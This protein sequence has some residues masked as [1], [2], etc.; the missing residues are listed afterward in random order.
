MSFQSL[1]G[2]KRRVH[3]SR[4]PFSL[5]FSCTAWKRQPTHVRSWPFGARWGSSFGPTVNQ[6]LKA[7]DPLY[8]QRSRLPVTVGSLP[9]KWELKKTQTFRR[10][11]EAA[12]LHKLNESKVVQEGGGW[13]GMCEWKRK[14]LLFPQLCP[15]RW[16]HPLGTWSQFSE[17]CPSAQVT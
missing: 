16:P 8:R 5:G 3:V 14:C 1:H 9:W 15:W 17:R 12:M 11:I 2:Q 10:G 13:M 7:E 4:T 6:P